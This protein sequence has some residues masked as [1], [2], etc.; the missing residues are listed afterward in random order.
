VGG[1]LVS[2]LNCQMKGTIVSTTNVKKSSRKS[3]CKHKDIKPVSEVSDVFTHCLRTA[4][5]ISP[6]FPL[7]RFAAMMHDIGKVPTKTYNTK[8]DDFKFHNH[9]V[10]GARMVD[11]VCKR[12]G[13]N[14]TERDYITKIVRHH[15]YIVDNSTKTKTIQRWMRNNP[16]YRDN[17]RLRMADRRGNLA[18]SEKPVLTYHLKKLI[19]NIRTIEKNQDKEICKV[20]EIELNLNGNDLIELGLIP[21]PLFKKIFMHLIEIVKKSPELNSRSLLIEMT[22]KYLD[23]L[24]R[25]NGTKTTHAIN[26]RPTTD[27]R[28]STSKKTT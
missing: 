14:D 3:T 6:R 22:Q 24:E 17:L 9:E 26:K 18:K 28:K 21:S 15:M 19:K 10:A 8:T 16:Y 27:L 23:T 20:K 25:T 11:A 5:A 1:K 2:E 4:D 7:L 12:L 13:F